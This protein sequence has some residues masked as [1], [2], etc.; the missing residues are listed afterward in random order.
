[1]VWGLGG[2]REWGG[3]GTWER[4]TRTPD[5]AAPP[6]PHQGVGNGQRGV[7]THLDLWRPH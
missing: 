3:E 4:C 5:P 6:P 2:V 7:R 1:M